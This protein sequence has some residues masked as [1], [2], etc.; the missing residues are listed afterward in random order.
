MAPP[1]ETTIHIDHSNIIL[2]DK[3]ESPF[4]VLLECTTHNQPKDVK[5][6][7]IALPYQV[8]KNIALAFIKLH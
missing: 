6:Y 2:G 4:P 1:K 7:V 5:K 3:S 8:A